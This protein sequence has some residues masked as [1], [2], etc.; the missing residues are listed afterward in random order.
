MP[1]PSW[2]TPLFYTARAAL[3]SLPAFF[4]RTTAYHALLTTT[5]ATFSPLYTL[6]PRFLSVV[7]PG[8]LPFPSH[9]I[10]LHTASSAWPTALPFYIPAFLSC[11]CLCAVAAT[12]L[13]AGRAPPP[14][15]IRVTHRHFAFVGDLPTPHY[16][17]HPRAFVYR[18]LRAFAH[19]T[20]THLPHYPAA[21]TLHPAAP[22]TAPL[23]GGGTFYA[24]CHTSTR[25]A[26]TRRAL[27]TFTSRVRRRTRRRTP[28]TPTCHA[29]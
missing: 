10:S 11:A 28:R 20:A 15:R 29:G 6:L 24:P 13:L 8:L 26:D 3:R 25:F 5:A 12:T 17:Q 22:G 4:I 14:T 21:P 1:I 16:A 27:R 9:H 2:R 7:V 23:Y 19:H 18:V